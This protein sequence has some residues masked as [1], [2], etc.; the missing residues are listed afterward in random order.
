[1]TS[2]AQAKAPLE[3]VRGLVFVGFPLHPAGQPGDGRGAHLAEVRVP[4]L[5]LQGTR[6]ALAERALLEPLLA[7]LGARASVELLEDADH[8]IH[9]PARSG[10]RDAD[11]LAAL[12]DRAAAWM[13]AAG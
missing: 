7:R 1:M 3:G 11:V 9:V 12:L 4:M 10:R 6:D 13:A 8:A 5:F 2:Q